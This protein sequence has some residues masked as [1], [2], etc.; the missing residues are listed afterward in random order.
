VTV[1]SGKLRLSV[2]ERIALGMTACTLPKAEWT[3]HAHLRA[4]LWHVLS[5]GE[6]PA[7]VL[8]RERITRY[9]ASVGTA[10]TD[11]SG[12]HETLTRFY[13][14]LIASFVRGRDRSAPLDVLA[15]ALIAEH[16]DRELPLRFYSR[17]RLFSV[18]ARHGWIEPDLLKS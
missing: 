16:G 17:E 5:F 13:V 4:G 14:G 15:A 6:E 2:T 1:E 9:N 8:L 12:Y 10:N 11:T 7:L 18:E 3:H